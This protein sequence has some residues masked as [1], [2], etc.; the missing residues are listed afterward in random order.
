M[1]IEPPNGLK[2]NLKQ[3][4]SAGGFVNKK[5]FENPENG[6][7]W[8]RL[9]FSIGFIHA[10]IHERK[11]FGTLGWNLPYEF[12]SSDFEVAI[13]QLQSVL[14]TNPVDVPFNVLKYV[15]GE[16]IYGGRVT[17]DYDRRC[18]LNMLENFF[19]QKAIE[20]SYYIGD[21][22][23]YEAPAKDIEYSKMIEFI[24]QLPD[25]DD[26][27]VFGMNIYAENMVRAV[28][29]DN[30]INAIL[31]MEPLQKASSRLDEI[32]NH[33][34]LVL[35]ICKEI[36]DNLT[37]EITP[38]FSRGKHMR[39][40]EALIKLKE[41][42]GDSYYESSTIITTV[43]QEIDRYNILLKVM[44]N[45]IKELEKAIKGEV[46]ISK[47]LENMIDSLVLQRVPD[48]WNVRIIYFYFF[49]SNSLILIETRISVAEAAGLMDQEPGQTNHL[50]LVVVSKHDSIRRGSN[51]T[52]Q[53]L[54]YLDI[55]LHIS[56]RPS[57]F[58]ISKVR[59]QIPHVN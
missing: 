33:N 48:V 25:E 54:F 29:A 21:N 18:L 40:D 51:S 23:S 52:H 19:C 36:R 20:D 26:P 49:L 17:D 9:V 3:N 55:G 39:F 56:S 7:N 24:D 58:N 6:P 53:S 35:G 12:N 50:L 10:L 44:F 34:D 15:T 22:E 27:S 1:T 47:S 28:Q 5:L 30:L 16:V 38:V 37:Q 8:K 4:F 46:V 2:N 14:T 59:T 11:K 57:G 43:K 13:L 32:I 42:L 41:I 45:S 31:T